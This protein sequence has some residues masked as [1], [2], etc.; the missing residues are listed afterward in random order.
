MT[1]RD[2]G[3]KLSTLLG[4]TSLD[5]SDDFIIKAVNWS[6]NELPRVSKLGK[7]FAKHYTVT[8]DAKNHYKWNLNQD[9]RRIND[10]PV[11]NFWTSTGGEPC[12]LNLCNKD[13]IEFYNRNGLPEMRKPG[14]PCEYTLE[15]ENDDIFLIIDRPSD[16]PIIVDYIAYGYPKPV[17]SMDDVV[18][19]SSIAE[20]LMLSVMKSIHYYEGQDFAFA[21]A[22]LQY[23]DSKALLEAQ[24]E[25]Y[26]RFSVE[27][28]TIVGEA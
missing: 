15:Q 17:S 28:P 12:R 23:L 5:L 25:L 10:I 21:E 1:I 19:I 3:T 27:D 13:T 11:M 20:N 18:D 7:L 6:F 26:K 24:Q 8:L 2:L 4:D 9:F 16:V 14:K 22:I